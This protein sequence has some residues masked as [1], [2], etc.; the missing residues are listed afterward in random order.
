M[1]CLET[2][3]ELNQ[4]LAEGKQLKDAYSE[5]GILI[6]RQEVGKREAPAKEQPEEEPMPKLPMKAAC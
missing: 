2:L 3:I 6:N 4:K 5:C 1:W